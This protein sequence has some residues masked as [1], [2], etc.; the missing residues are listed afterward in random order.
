MRCVGLAT[1]VLVLSL[2]G[3]RR[4]GTGPGTG[5]IDPGRPD[6]HAPC[7]EGAPHLLVGLTSAS[8][9]SEQAVARFTRDLRQ[10]RGLVVAS[11]TYGTI[12]VVGGLPDGTDL[13]GFAASYGRGGALVR[14]GPD[15]ELGRVESTS[16]YPIS[17]AAVMFQSQPAVA[18][19]WG[20]G[21]SSSDHG[22]RVE[23]YAQSDLRVLASWEVSYAFVR[24]A[25]AP[26]GQPE[27]LAGAINEGLQEYR[28]DP[29]ATSLATTG[30]LRVAAPNGVGYLRSLDVAGGHARATVDRGVLSW[31]HGIAPAFLGPVHCVWPD[32]ADTELPVSDAT[33]PSAVIE[34]AS[35][36][37]SLVVVR[38]QLEGGSDELTHIYTMR[39]RGECRHEMS[40]A[41]SHAAVSLAWS[42]R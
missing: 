6:Q 35:P 21:Q 19:A 25:A 18:V 38:G 16:E 37:E 29:G 11:S 3:C 10:C 17:I 32:T 9:S 27:R 36:E 31:Q 14:F 39:R 4:P 5:P 1:L 20:S 13:V 12:R 24:V 28:A 33:Y 7:P 15:R 26:S 42:G 34:L 23:V 22:E 40:F 2:A 41:R 30:E 8:S